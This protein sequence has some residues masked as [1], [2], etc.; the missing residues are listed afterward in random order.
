MNAKARTRKTRT[1][2]LALCLTAALGQRNVPAAT[3]ASAADCEGAACAQVTLTFDDARQQYR[4]QNN[5]A[6]HWV[7]VDAS[8]LAGSAGACLAPGK[9]EYVSLK[10]I[11]GAYRAAY[12]AERCGATGGA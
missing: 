11:V 7:R 8:N 10:S 12:A 2:A 4:A 5:S 6:D 1:F 9:V 3:A